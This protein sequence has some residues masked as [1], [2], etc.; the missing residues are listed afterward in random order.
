MFR[1]TVAKYFSLSL[2]IIKTNILT[3]MEYR[4]SFLIQVLGMIVNDVALILVWVIFFKQFPEIRGR[5][6]SD[7]VMLYAITTINFGL[8]MALFRGSFE[9]ARTISRGELDYFL[10]LPKNV[11]WHVSVSKSE[12]SAIGDTIFGILIFF[13]SGD[14]TPQ[15]IFL[16]I[17]YI[18]IS[19]VIL[20]SFTVITQ[21][22][23]FWFGNFEEAAEQI[24]HTL[25]GFTLYP[26]TVFHGLLK[27][28][29]LTFIPAFFIATLPVQLIRNFDLAL[30]LVMLVYAIAIFGIA[31]LIF[32][33]GLKSYE[34]GN[35][36]NVRI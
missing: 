15:K 26:Q 30:T 4:T 31:V 21:S 16:F 3:A 14:I 6:F 28:V 10:A 27:I 24:F 9:L 34:S 33:A 17:F 20:Y 18:I 12:I 36:I 23:A 32:K 25:I 5:T 8:V 1:S 22:L 19:S 13:V 11:L 7:T 2:E 35:L 29:M